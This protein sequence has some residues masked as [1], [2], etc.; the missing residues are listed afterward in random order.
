[1]QERNTAGYVV[2]LLGP[3][4]GGK[5][6]QAVR[7]AKELGL[8]HFSTGEILREEVRQGS[9]LGRQ[10]KAVM[11]SG[12]LVSDEILGRIVRERLSS[13]DGKGCILDGYPRN[14]AQAEFLEEARNGLRLIVVNLAVP[15]EAIVKRLSGR[16]FCPRCGTV[17]NI[18]F[19]PPKVDEI[20]DQCGTELQRRE[21]DREEVIRERLRVYREVTQPVVDYYAG[22]P[23]FREIDGDGAP[24]VVYQRLLAAV[25]SLME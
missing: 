6:T 12:A 5:G 22:R 20:C 10:V 9:E 23:E 17:Y 25:K 1:M 4:G 7:L 15:E 16:R 19:S 3:P 18:Y 8:E 2:V 13:L 24:E 21:D 11:E 14:L